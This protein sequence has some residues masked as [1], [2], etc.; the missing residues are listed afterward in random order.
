MSI[1]RQKRIEEDF[2]GTLEIPAEALWGIQTARACANFPVTGRRVNP[3]LIRAY[4]LVKKAS[5][6]T[7]RE[8]EYLDTRRADAITAACD[9]IAGGGL[10]D[11]F[12]VDALQG[13]AGT[14]TNMNLNE[15]I[16]NRANE[17]L[18]L[19]GGTHTGDGVHPLDHVNLHQSTNDTYPT[20]LKVCLTGMVRELAPAIERLQGALQKK[21][22]EFAGIVTVGR[23]ELQSAVPMTLGAEF[24]AFAE[25]IG[26]DRWRTFKCEERL[27]VVNLGGTAVGT[28][29]AA[30]RRYIFRVTDILRELTG[31]GLARAENLIDQTANADSLVE[32]SGILRA[33]AANL[34]KVSRDLRFLAQA[35]E[36]DLPAV[37]AGSTIMPGKVNPVILEAVIQAGMKAR[38]ND[39][40]LGEAV[41]HGSL[42]I[43]EYMPLIADLMIESIEL[44]QNSSGMLA[45]QVDGIAANAENCARRLDA[46]PMI[47][48][49]LL[50]AIGY[51]RAAALLKEYR[52]T[53]GKIT[54]RAF[55]SGQLG[56]ELIERTFSPAALS[57][58]GFQ[59]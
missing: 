37:Q 25:C 40:L 59:D 41:A 19:P 22:K 56:E 13:G 23:T 33:H 14:S 24:S 32:V 15:V 29:L 49:A 10:S 57:A 3:R 9:E 31:F 53:G 27:R 54:L 38:S 44:L 1:S 12:P 51:E 17:L 58:L 4:A 45:S 7:N 5:C 30:P 48:T 36:I 2:L 47:I 28:G 6:L 39:A 18:G 52:L 55:L 35:G 11:Q 21:E 43:N 26:R 42:Q 8:L 34:I 20:A 50:P 16:A 46:D